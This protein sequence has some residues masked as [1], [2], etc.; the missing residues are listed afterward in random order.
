EIEPA[1]GRLGDVGVAVVGRIERAPE[2]ADLHPRRE[3]QP[4]AQAPG[5]GAESLGGGTG[6][7]EGQG[8]LGR[9]GRL[10]LTRALTRPGGAVADLQ[11]GCR[12]KVSPTSVA[13]GPSGPA[14][15]FSRSA[16]RLTA[17]SEVEASG[18][19]SGMAPLSSRPSVWMG[20]W[21]VMAELLSQ[22]KRPA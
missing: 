9:R 12:L 8:G 11:P 20:F 17:S 3:V 6:V 15:R 7:E 13:S 10:M 19:P 4:V 18:R 16:L 1:Q 5:A 14:L 2:E 22:G 21:S